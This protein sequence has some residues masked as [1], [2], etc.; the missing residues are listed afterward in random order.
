[1]PNLPIVHS[2]CAGKLRSAQNAGI[3]NIA[4]PLSYPAPQCEEIPARKKSRLEEDLLP[5]TTTTSSS[6]TDEAARKTASPD[7]S[8][9]IPPPAVDNDD[10]MHGV[11]DR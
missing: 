1:M 10:A 7:V 2:Q 3:K 4:A 9:G 11:T 6:T 8:V 5:A